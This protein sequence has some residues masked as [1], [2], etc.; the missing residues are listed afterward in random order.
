MGK[1]KLSATALIGG[2]W[3]IHQA[4][5][6]LE[7]ARMGRAQE[8]RAQEQ[9]LHML[10]SMQQ[11]EQVAAYMRNP[12]ASEILGAGRLAERDDLAAANLFSNKGL[13]IGQFEGEPIFYNGDR[14]ALS[15]GRT[16]SGKGV[17]II[18]PVLGSMKHDSFIVT[19]IKDAENAY[20]TAA[21]RAELGHRIL[22]LNPLNI[23]GI[24][25]FRLNPCQAMLDIARAGYEM[26]GED[27]QFIDKFLP[28]TP[29][30]A[31]SDNAWA[32][33]GA[34]EILRIRAKYL[35]YFKPEQCNPAGLWHMVNG[36]D[37]DIK[38]QYQEMIVSGTH[39]PS[40]SDLSPSRRC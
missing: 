16:R 4:F 7:S 29:K 12:K 11:Y 36:S 2:A 15:Y 5:Q 10:Q 38:G 20:A 33:E 40:I 37:E 28:M 35:A 30:Q 13:Y 31:Q 32:L 14:H 18:L 19:D 6:S 27:Q 9:H 39:S 34:R 23:A 8:E 17:D 22:A 26:D 3:A 1:G 25:S 24:E 21:A